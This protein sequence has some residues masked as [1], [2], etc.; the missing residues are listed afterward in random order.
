MFKKANILRLTSLLLVLLTLLGT[1]MATYRH[2]ASKVTAAAQAKK[3]AHK[4]ESSKATVQAVSF[5]AIISFVHFN[6]SQD[7]YF[8]FTPTFSKLYLFVHHSFEEPAFINTYFKNTF[9]H[10]IAINAP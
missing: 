2:S 5:E 9:C 4:E 8:D 3:A 1:S 7:F 6:L 10:H